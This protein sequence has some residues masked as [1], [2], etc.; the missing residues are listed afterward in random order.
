MNNKTSR[1]EE[2]RKWSKLFPGCLILTLLSGGAAWALLDG[3]PCAGAPAARIV[4][5]KI[6]AEEN[7]GIRPAWKKDLKKLISIS[8]ATFKD[9][10][11]IE[12]R[13]AAWECW[14]PERNPDSLDS[15]LEDLKRKVSPGEADI[16]VGLVAPA[17]VDDPPAGIADYFNG[18]ALLKFADPRAVAPIMLHELGHIFGA[19]DLEEEGS[20]MD[21][22]NPGF[23]FDPFSARII[24][25]NRDRSFGAGSFPF[26]PSLTNEVLAAF[27]TRA[28]L[29]RRE[30][31][32]HLFL[33]YLYLES[34]DD[35]RA[36][37]EC[38]EVLKAGPDSTEVRVLLGNLRLAR[39]DADAASAE[40]ERILARRP[41]LPTVH[42]NLGVAR[43]KMEMTNEAIGAF[44]NAVRLKPEY[45]EAHVNLGRLYLKKGDVDAAARHCRTA[46]AI[47]PAAA[48]GLCI[49]SVALILKE[50]ERSLEEAIELGRKAVALRPQLPEAH[51]ILG[52]AC[53]RSG[54]NE[55]AE[56][57]LSRALELRPDSLEVHLSLAWLFKNTGRIDRADFHLT[58]IAELEPDFFRR[59]HVQSPFEVVKL[60]TAN[61][62]GQVR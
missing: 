44:E 53:G 31:E 46:L 54:I 59:H 1:R 6:A 39:G 13:I 24:R 57:E 11:G 22:R 26:P 29:N 30:P 51:A 32:L 9:Q 20:V 16:V 5:V 37:G 33:A 52:I 18:C 3:T 8:S 62:V 56:R 35:A 45:I 60:R 14:R 23:E 15:V 58:R 19:V 36:A 25:L 38:L 41:D 50:D 27:R 34:G 42:F 7:L 47:S 17:F 61:L 4:T 10:V 40:Y 49:L 28:S 2:R 43:S 12:F 55:E 21:P 48:E